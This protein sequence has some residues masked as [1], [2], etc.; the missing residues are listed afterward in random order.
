[1]AL[2]LRQSKVVD[3]LIL[4]ALRRSKSPQEIDFLLTCYVDGL[5]CYAVAKRLPAGVMALPVQGI[6]DA[7]ARLLSLRAAREH[8][9]PDAAGDA[10][11]A[12]FDE[13]A[14]VFNVAVGCLAGHA[15]GDLEN[16]ATRRDLRS[17][18]AA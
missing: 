3:M 13:V 15:R 16:A 7:E 5:Q 1:M 11:R 4:E 17:A 9:S 10:D 14:E 2:R 12:I 8:A 18:H 6:D